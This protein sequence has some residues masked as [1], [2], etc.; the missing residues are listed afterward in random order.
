MTYTLRLLTPMVY[1]VVKHIKIKLTVLKHKVLKI[2]SML[3]VVIK[4]LYFQ[5]FNSL[6]LY[7]LVGD[8]SLR[9]H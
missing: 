1:I 6:I 4:N 5:F 7:L 2:Y 8:S 3:I 9:R